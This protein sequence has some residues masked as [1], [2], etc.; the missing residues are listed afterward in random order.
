MAKEVEYRQ[1]KGR[2]EEIPVF[3][4]L[5]RSVVK[6]GAD[7]IYWRLKDVRAKRFGSWEDGVWLDCE[8]GDVGLEGNCFYWWNRDSWLLLR[9]RHVWYLGTLSEW[10][11][12]D[13]EIEPRL[14]ARLAEA[15]EFNEGLGFDGPEEEHP[16]LA[17]ANEVARFY[18]TRAR[19]ARL[20]EEA[21]ADGRKYWDDD[22]PETS[23][24]E[25]DALRRRNDRFDLEDCD[26]K[27]F[28]VPVCWYV[29]DSTPPK[30]RW[31]APDPPTKIIFDVPRSALVPYYQTR[32]REISRRLRAALADAS[33]D[34]FWAEIYFTKMEWD[35]D[36]GFN[37]QTRHAD[38]AFL[39]ELDEL[40]AETR[41]GTSS[42]GEE[43]D[44]EFAPATRSDALSDDWRERLASLLDY[45]F[46]RWR[47]VFNA[48]L[49]I[50]DEIVERPV[51]EMKGLD[52]WVAPGG[53]K[54][55][56]AYSA[57]ENASW[58]KIGTLLELYKEGRVWWGA[59]KSKT[60][61]KHSKALA[62]FDL[63]KTVWRRLE[64]ALKAEK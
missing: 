58:V 22:W 17:A 48:A 46:E 35:L 52:V 34:S 16:F 3:G 61:K 41:A 26:P 20:A 1:I 62:H 51:R 47:A 8:T 2:D 24:E 49:R 40:V 27:I 9:S 7:K 55:T 54:A 37:F 19:L 15:C 31:D 6:R 4:N 28:Q 43:A 25:L 44:G 29:K 33:V 30:R 60:D 64:A 36:Y 53:G 10:R 63:A 56:V 5:S 59:S 12:P 11:G 39:G 13:S 50:Y 23:A 57:P 45:R 18:E 32:S 38:M 21:D 14:A 42:E